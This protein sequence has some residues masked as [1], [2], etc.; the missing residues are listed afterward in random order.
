MART[1]NSNWKRT[2]FP[3]LVIDVWVNLAKFYARQYS[4]P[5]GC[6]YMTGPKHR[7]GYP[8]IGGRRASNESRMMMTCHRLAYKIAHG[9]PGQ[10][11]VLHTCSDMACVNP[12]HL[13]LGDAKTKMEI[14][15]AAGRHYNGSDKR[16]AY[17][18]QKNRKYKYTEEE[19]RWVRNATT[20]EIALK[21]GISKKRAAAR[22]W[23]WT[24][25]SYLWIV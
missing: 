10:D 9:D 25:D 3:D 7:Q 16:R 15:V 1:K 11:Q 14:C 12:Q 17:G 6:I 24:N 4:S 8:M 18:R 19:I 22:R 20:D 23:S 2:V 21:Y 5:H 13:I